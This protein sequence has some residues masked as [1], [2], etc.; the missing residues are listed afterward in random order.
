MHTQKKAHNIT[1][2]VNSIIIQ[3]HE[4]ATKWVKCELLPVRKIFTLI[5]NSVS[6]KWKIILYWIIFGIFFHVA[7]T[8]KLMDESLKMIEKNMSRMIW[9][10]ND[11]HLIMIYAYDHTICVESWE[12]TDHIWI[13]IIYTP[14]TQIGN[15]IYHHLVWDFENVFDPPSLL[16]S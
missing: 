5:F 10:N 4:L 8:S 15:W 14:N 16:I 6:R 2:S 13:T 9:L 12:K 7:T 1:G 11:P 3:H